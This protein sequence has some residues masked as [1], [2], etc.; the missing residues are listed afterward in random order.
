MIVTSFD[1]GFYHLG[2]VKATI[3]ENEI[4]SFDYCNLINVTDISQCNCSCPYYSLGKDSSHYVFHFMQKYEELLFKSSDIILMEKQQMN[5]GASGSIESSITTWCIL[6]SCKVIK[7]TPQELQIFHR[8]TRND[9]FEII[10]DH[11]LTNNKTNLDDIVYNFRKDIMVDRFEDSIKHL[12][13]FKKFKRQH[14]MIDAVGIIV[15]YVTRNYNHNININNPFD[16]FKYNE[17]TKIEA[18]TNKKSKYFT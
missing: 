13:N 16:T 11:L 1:I 5:S 17:E 6:N 8:V 15:Y 3:S 9:L 7:F 12:H 2:V 14:D 4:K 10:P 18:V